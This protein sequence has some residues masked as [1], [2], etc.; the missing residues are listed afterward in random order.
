MATHHSLWMLSDAK[1][2]LGQKRFTKALKPVHHRLLGAL[3][4]QSEEMT[5]HN[6]LHLVA[7]PLVFSRSRAGRGKGSSSDISCNIIC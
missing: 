2:I 4:E 1:S 7:F 6:T 5:S 3:A